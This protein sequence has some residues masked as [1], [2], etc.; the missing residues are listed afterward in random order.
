M[1]VAAYVEQLGAVRSAPTVKQHLAAIRHL[2]DYLVTGH[3][4]PFNPAAAVRGPR[5]SVK[6]GKTPVLYEEEARHLL[7]SI[8]TRTVIGLRDRALLSLMTYSFARVGAVVRMRVKDFHT[9]GHRAWFTLHEKGGKCRQVPA[10]HKAADAVQAYL[11]AADIAGDREGRLFRSTG[12][13]GRGLGERAL[14]TVD[15]FRMIKRR[16]KAA[17]FGAEL[18]CHTFRATGLTNYL[19]NGGTLETGAEIAGHASTRTT[20]LY[21]RRQEKVTQA[22]IERIRI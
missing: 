6:E 15:V 13:R 11:E 18:C 12:G 16:A 22:E 21:D 10:H 7:S 4:L 8:E 3:I 5:Y 19:I 1:A 2:F 14:A 20:Q 9:Q 17:G